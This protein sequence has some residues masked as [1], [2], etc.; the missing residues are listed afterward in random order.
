MTTDKL[1]YFRYM[2]QQKIHELLDD[3]GKTVS[4]M[5]TGQENFPDPNDLATFVSDRTF[6]LRIRDRERKLIVKL[7]ETIK[8][9]DDET[10]GICE[11]CGEQISEKRLLARPVTTHCIDCKSKLEK[12]EKIIGD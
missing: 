1:K 2:L 3:A 9:I 10:Y 5:T 4:E 8:R 7:Q 6:E 11:T 12:L